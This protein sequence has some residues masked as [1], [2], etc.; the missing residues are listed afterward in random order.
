MVGFGTTVVR[1]LYSEG[2]RGSG[3]GSYIILEITLRSQVE[4]YFI[5]VKFFQSEAPE[6]DFNSKTIGTRPRLYTS[7]IRVDI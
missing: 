3:L 1:F 2:V 4:Y 7:V 6:V 5:H